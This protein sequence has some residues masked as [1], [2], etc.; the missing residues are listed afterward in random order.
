MPRR[1]AA[2]LLALLLP[3]CG[4]S[5]GVLDG[6]RIHYTAETSLSSTSDSTIIVVGEEGA[7]DA[8]GGLLTIEVERTGEA[9]PAAV[10]PDTGTLAAGAS[11]RQGDTLRL[12]HSA[13]G[14]DSELT[15]VLDEAIA[16]VPPP[17]C[18]ACGAGWSLVGPA[19]GGTASVDLSVLDDPTAPF[20]VSNVDGGA[21]VVAY[22]AETE[23]AIPAVPGAQVCVHQRLSGV[24][25]PARCEVVR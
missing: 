25:G 21:V 7:I 12:V 5:S 9:F 22:T 24:S 16:S 1:P 10:D 18:T 11:A 23:V 2:V 17:S 3:A 14:A 20:F 13:D 8:A 15:L 4:G 6:G 19:V